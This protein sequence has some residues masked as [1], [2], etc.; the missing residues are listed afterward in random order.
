MNIQVEHIDTTGA[1]NNLNISL[2]RL[3]FVKHMAIAGQGYSPSP[4]KLM[5]TFGMFFHYSNYLQKQAFDNDHF[6]TPPRILSDP[7]EQ[8]Q[9]SNIAGKA[10]ADFLSKRIDAS[11]FT[12]NYEAVATRPMHGQRPDLVAYSPK[13]V[14]TLEAKGRQQGNPG[15]MYIHKQQAGSGNYPRNFSVACVS[16][17][18]FNNVQCNY[19][20]PY[21]N[22]IQYDSEGL[23]KSSRKYY[24]GLSDFL[25]ESYFQINQA[26]Y[27]EE[28]FYEVELSFRKFRKFL[29]DEFLSY[30][31]LLH[32][33]FEFY[34]P[35]LILPI[36]IAEYA[37]NGL[38][39]E[40][41]PFQ[42]IQEGNNFYIDT[43][44]IG[45]RI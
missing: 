40:T 22:N 33:M 43:D 2:T 24:S 25:N 17:N 20:D 39:R 29:Q 31:L 7:T 32:E 11:F 27:G 1:T 6:S 36:N 16:Y 10:I 23:R 19:H 28:I 9:F 21:N 26:T 42:Q 14:F 41:K 15:N 30:P 5:R 18:I 35:R 8:A 12:L 45:L 13:G 38:T 37:E 34:R 44:R 3:A 4:R